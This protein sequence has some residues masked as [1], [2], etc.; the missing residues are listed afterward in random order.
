[1][2]NSITFIFDVRGFDKYIALGY[3]DAVDWYLRW[4]RPPLDTTAAEAAEHINLLARAGCTEVSPT[5]SKHGL[6]ARHITNTDYVYVPR[7]V[8]DAAGRPVMEDGEYK[9]RQVR[10]PRS[11]INQDRPARS[12]GSYSREYDRFSWLQS[13]VYYRKHKDRLKNCNLALSSALKF[14]SRRKMIDGQIH[15]GRPA[16][17]YGKFAA[18]QREKELTL[19]IQESEKK[20]LKAL[21]SGKLLTQEE[22][23]LR[24][25]IRELELERDLIRQRIDEI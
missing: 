20:L 10:K 7:G 5:H 19:Q 2:A 22:L 18:T 17:G 3:R 25:S 12:G 21:C 4:V 13:A 14:A 11:E 23:G 15:S 9:G 6:T 1:M 8:V 24:Q 16:I